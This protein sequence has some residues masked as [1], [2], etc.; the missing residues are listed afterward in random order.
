MRYPFLLLPLLLTAAPLSAQLLR[1]RLVEEGRETPLT[2]AFVVLEDSAGRR[3][4]RTPASPS[5]RFLLEAPRA[6]RFHLRILRIGF[7]PWEAEIRLAAGEILD[8]TFIL[9]PAPVVLPEIAVAGAERCGGRARLDTLAG[10][11]WLQAG[12]ALA[13]TNA[14]VRSHAYRF[15]TI[16]EERNVDAS[17]RL[18]TARKEPEVG[19]SRWPVQ[20][21]PLDSLL[22]SGFVENLEDLVVGPTWYGPDADFLLS[23]AFFDTHCFRTVPPGEADPPGVIGLAFA[24]EASDRRADIRGTLWLDRQTAELRRLEFAY[25]RLP[26]WART[27]TAGGSLG[28]APLPGGGWIVQRW[29]LRVP[30]PQVTVGTGQAK[31]S[32]YLESDGHVSAVLETDGRLVQRF[33]D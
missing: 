24:P 8:R 28:F 7:A 10:A 21:P 23:D 18:S 33:P 26:S 29:S 2:G 22:A 5:G 30:V 17:G 27:A 1:G 19:I 20:S 6:G 25:T 14:T 11:I 15:E 13:L 31:L 4:A 3:V 32:G 16:L 9:S 12:T